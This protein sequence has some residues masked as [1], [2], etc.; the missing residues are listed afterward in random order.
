MR[1]LSSD[2]RPAEAADAEKIARVHWLAWQQVYAGILPHRA[3]QD[4]ISGRNIAWWKNAIASEETL[5]VLEVQGQPVGY[6]SV[7]LNR[8]KAL[9]QEGEI[10]EI[11][12]LPEYQGL[13]FGRVLFAEARRLLAS[14]GCKGT[15]CWCFEALDHAGIFFTALG[16]KPFAFAEEEHGGKVLGKVSYIWE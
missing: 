12:L 1:I 14:L 15:I 5:L 6:A 9:P 7:G 4:M 8:V 16:G 10:Y 13:G 2:V 11:Y 3:L